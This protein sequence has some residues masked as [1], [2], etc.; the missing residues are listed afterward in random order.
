MLTLEEIFPPFAL[1]II[2]GPVSLRVLRDEDLP[3][4]VDVV[5]AGV[6]AP[7]LPMPFAQPW[8]EAPFEPGRP[9]AFPATSLRWWWRQRSE[10]APERW[11]LALVVRREGEIVGM[12]D[13]EADSYPLTRSLTTGSWL[14]RPHHGRGTGTLMRQ[15]VVGFAFDH[16]GALECHSAYIEGNEASARVSRKAGYLPNGRRRTDQAGRVGATLVGVRVIPDTFVRPPHP[17]RVRGAE[18]LRTFLA[19]EG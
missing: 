2:C 17:L 13:L 12:Q 8:H 6:V 10:C 15:A 16:L 7:E 9:D 18:A 1:E 3:A 11:R 4:L 14:G 5:A 19:I